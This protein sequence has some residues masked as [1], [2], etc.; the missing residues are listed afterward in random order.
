IVQLVAQLASLG[1]ETAPTDADR[2]AAPINRPAQPADELALTSTDPD[3]VSGPTDA[4]PN[5]LSEWLESQLMPRIERRHARLDALATDVA[6][7]ER[8]VDAEKQAE[9]RHRTRQKD[10]TDERRAIE[11]AERGL[12]DA[13]S[14]L[15]RRLS[16]CRTETAPHLGSAATWETLFTA[17]EQG[18]RDS[19]ALALAT[20]EREAGAAS[21]RDDSEQQQLSQEIGQLAQTLATLDGEISRIQA[22]PDLDPPRRPHRERART[23]LRA[24]GVEA[25]PLYTLIDFAPDLPDDRR[26]QVER[27]LDDAGLLDALVLRD[28]DLSTAEAIL[29]NV[30]LADC[31]FVVDEP[32]VDQ[33]LLNTV[34]V[35]DATVGSAEWRGVTERALGAIASTA[36]ATTPRVTFQATGRWRHGLLAGQSG[37]GEAVGF[38]GTANRRE[39]RQREIDRRVTERLSLGERL[40]GL[41]AERDRLRQAQ[42]DRQRAL[43]SLRQAADDRPIGAAEVRL[44][45]RAQALRRAET[46]AK[47][48]ADEAT[49]RAEERQTL[50]GQIEGQATRLLAV[51]LPDRGLV[52]TALR[53]GD[54]LTDVCKLIQNELGQLASLQSEQFLDRGRLTEV[55]VLIG[56]AE[57]TVTRVHSEQQIVEE[58]IR[59]AQSLLESGDLRELHRQRLDLKERESNLSAE[60]LTLAHQLGS[61]QDRVATL[62]GAVSS[63]SEAVSAAEIELTN[64]LQTF[65]TMLRL[66]PDVVDDAP[67]ESDEDV[68]ALAHGWEAVDA[69]NP[70]QLAHTAEQAREH[71][72][73]VF[74]E[75]RAEL[76][77]YNLVVAADERDRV[78]AQLSLREELALPA[79]LSTIQ[80]QIRDNQ[81][82]LNAEE[83]RLF[84]DYLCDT[85][86]TAIHRAVQEADKLVW[87]INDI[88]GRTLLG[89][90]RYELKLETALDRIEGSSPLARHHALFRKDPAAIADEE[91]RVLFEAVRSAVSEARRRFADEGGVFADHLAQAFDYREWYTLQLYVTDENGQRMRISSRTARAR[92]GAQQL[93]A[94]YVPLFA[95]L[96]ALYHAAESWAPR[97]FSMDEAFDKV[98]E[99]NVTLLL[100]FLVDLD[101]QWIVAS[102]RL[103][104]AGRDV[105]P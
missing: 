77:D 78:V 47:E 74:D 1:L 28:A 80:Q 44:H 60:Q 66:N 94:L 81:L 11:D 29:N 30:G 85:G 59:R 35:V 32:A 90:E 41:E 49:R 43:A 70:D 6:A 46:A 56:E 99:D 102:P 96:A 75:R 34:L 36:N 15:V 39:R 79:L 84:K 5:E 88:L 55:V 95:A 4:T 33:N 7:Y 86:L 24:A 64:A 103:S 100:R 45:E 17:A 54:R 40:S 52:Q 23:A 73:A 104:G 2:E 93:F 12:S 27:M 31:R 37:H 13:W 9:E 65:T 16:E 89:R 72:R 87:R 83:E 50:A 14:K 38:I 22:E 53:A 20:I 18:A 8:A 48:A 91:R 58:Q 10:L 67:V 51:A 76:I 105:L 3:Q 57:A 19:L 97:L 63:L 98:S 92:S 42:R 71:R 26:G 68:L 61:L 21:T 62:A 69:A 101:F 25:R 82:L